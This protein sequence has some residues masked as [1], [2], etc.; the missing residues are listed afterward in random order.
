MSQQRIN[1]LLPMAGGSAL[2]DPQLYPYPLPLTELCGKPM[3]EHVINN[4]ATLAASHDELRFICVVKAE[5][6]NRFHLDHTLELL[7]PGRIEVVKLAADTQGALCS[8]LMAIQHIHN[9]DPLVIANV[10][11]LIEPGL[12]NLFAELQASGCDAGCLSFD[13]VHP[14]WSYV[15]VEGDGLVVEA[16]EKKPI[17]RHA[18][19]GFYYFAKGRLFVE[20]AQRTVLNQS[21]VG[22][23]FFVSLAFNELILDGKTV[24]ALT[25]PQHQYHSFYTPQ[26][27]EDYERERARANRPMLPIGFAAAANSHAASATV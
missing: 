25:V 5:D 16:A 1:V 22:A 9:D 14:R 17:S 21:S 26:R 19:A 7:A 6:C 11:Q 23:Q 12:K 13:A 2:F 27:I 20:A 3:I 24:R 18:I 10:D 4:L 8:A 15:R